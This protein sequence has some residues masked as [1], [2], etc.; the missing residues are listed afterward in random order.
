MISNE[1]AALLRT[2]GQ[3]SS[4]SSTAYDSTMMAPSSTTSSLLLPLVT[5]ITARAAFPK[6]LFEDIRAAD[7]LQV[8]DID[9]LWRRF[10]LSQA[11]YDLSIPM[12]QREVS[13]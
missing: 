10:H 11:N 3:G 1:E 12:T 2:S 8:A 13:R 6:L 7:D 5:N 4:S 9:L